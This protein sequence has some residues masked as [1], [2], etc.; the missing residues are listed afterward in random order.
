MENTS[1]TFTGTLYIVATP[2]GNLNDIS[3]RATKTLNEVDFVLAEDTRHSKPLL[4]ALGINT[5]LLSLHDHNEADKSHEIINEL[6]KGISFALISDAGTPLISDPGFI[7]VRLA[8]QEGINVVPIPGACAIITALCAAGVPCENFLFVGFLPAKSQARLT[9]LQTFFDI[10]H[11]VVFYESTHRIIDC[12]NDIIET[13]G[14]DYQWV[15]AKELTK[16]YEH[17][18]HAPGHEIYAWI[19]KDKSR[20]KGEF[21]IILPPVVRKETSNNDEK[22]LALLLEELSLKQAVRLGALLSKTNKNE[23]YKLALDIQK[24]A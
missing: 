5:T 16:S 11:T 13:Y 19:T 20:V 15:L 12:I 3:L 21:V 10:D 2:I 4:N 23:L 7:L 24:N 1:A 14:P 6:K 17:I 9:K 8:K 22:I 18:M